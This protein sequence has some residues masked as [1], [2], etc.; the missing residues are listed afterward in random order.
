MEEIE[1]IE[2]GED[3]PDEII[4]LPPIDEGNDTDADSGEEDCNDP[5][6]LNHGQMKTLAEIRF[7]DDAKQ[8]LSEEA[9]FETKPP[10][11]KSKK[12]L[13]KWQKVTHI[14]DIPSEKFLSL[15]PVLTLAPESHPI[16]FFNL[17]M[18]QDIVEHL[19][20]ETEE[21]A[22]SKNHNISLSKDEFYVFL[23]ILIL[24][25]YVPLPRRR[26]YWENVEDTKNILVSKSMRRNRFEQI[27]RFFHIADNNALPVDDKLAKVRPLIEK[28]NSKFLCYAPIQNKISIDESMIPYFGRNGCKQFIRGKPIRF[29]Y[30]AWTMAL[31]NGYCLNFDVYQG[32]KSKAYGEENFGLGETVVL[33]FSQILKNNFG[34]MKFSLFFDNFFTSTKLLSSLGNI[35]FTGTGTVRENRTEKCP[36]EDKKVMMKKAR[37]SYCSAFDKDNNIVAIRW[38]DN[39]VL[40]IMSNEYGI[41]PIQQASRYSAQEKRRTE[42]NQP[43]LI[44]QYNKY[45]GGVDLLDNNISNYRINI[46]GKKWYFPIWLWMLDICV[47]NAW[48]LARQFGNKMDHLEFRRLIARYLLSNYGKPKNLPGPSSALVPEPSTSKQ[49]LVVTAQNRRRCRMCQNKTVKL[50]DTC[51][52]PLHDK[53][54]K[55]YHTKYFK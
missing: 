20:K 41:N 48:T 16:E 13:R 2:R 3:L 5:D 21:Y 53:C 36:L 14:P 42:I 34:S 11:K 45:M 1:K 47:V 8:P 54:F 25:G 39:S 55:E 43:F 9:D 50:C 32:R 27:F 23:G 15:L 6:K 33:N 22:N 19:L 7:D 12:A 46:R 37:G 30:K 29:G 51:E 35:G 26:M 38:K 28:L 17:F 10:R 44:S 40:T 49:H 52:V 31:P 24:S 18:S 4:I